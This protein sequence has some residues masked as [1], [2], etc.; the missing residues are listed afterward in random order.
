MKHFKLAALT[1]ALLLSLHAHAAPVSGID[2]KNFDK[3]VRVQDDIYLHTNGTWIKNTPIPDDKPYWGAFYELRETSLERSRK[4]LE[5]AAANKSATGDERKIGD[6]YTSYMDEATIEKRGTAPVKQLLAR[7][8]QINTPA[9]IA[10]YMGEVQ[11]NPGPQPMNISVEINPKDSTRYFPGAGQGGLGLPDRDYYLIDDARFVAARAAYQ[12]YLT[13]LFTLIGEKDAENQAKAVITLETALAK[14]QWSKVDNRD[15]VKTYNKL[16]VAQ[17]QKLSPGFDWTVFLDAAGYGKV[18]EVDLAQPSFATELGKLVQNQPVAT[19]RAYFKAHQLDAVARI[20]PK[21]FSD[22]SFQFHSVALS[23]TPKEPPRWQRAVTAAD[24]ALGEAVGKEYVAQYFPP[25]YKTRMQVLVGNLMKAYDQSIGQ[26]TWMTPETKKAAQYKLAHYALKIGYPD[27]WRDYT[28]LEI[29]PDDLFGNY[30]RAAQFEYHRELARL[31]DPVD[32]TEWG[33]TP[34]TVNAYYNPAQ[35][36]IVFPAAI[37]QPPFF[38]MAADDAANYGAIGAVI[39][40]EISHGFD[41]QG[42]HFDA[43]GN[44]NEWWTP[45]DRKRFTALTDKLVAQY[46][47]YE[48]L[49]GQHVNG[50]LTLGENIADNSGLQIA[51]KAYHLAL[52]DK[53]A[54]VIDGL[55]GDQRFFLAFAQVWRSKMREAFQLQLLKSDPHSPGNFRAIGATENNDAFFSAFDVKPGD[56]M[57]KAPEQ[58]IHIW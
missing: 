17:L 36:E 58:R 2:L 32:R 21:D 46:D 47:A 5:A 41:D 48:P 3:N 50:K 7:I 9:D 4:I 27:K 8:D 40:H 10:R 29:K 34:Q 23:G 22:A 57:Y 55:T 18:P 52:G 24:W 14:A 51:Y 28:A 25:E 53:P 54:P 20:L 45:E 16:T 1:G 44:L 30:Q 39:G 49:P 43:V 13:R 33:M 31:N 42:S 15:P 56:K 19:W 6:F 12:T 11:P 37:L 38:N 35:N 26:L